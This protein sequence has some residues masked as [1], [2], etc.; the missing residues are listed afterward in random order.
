MMLTKNITYAFS[1]KR[2]FRSDSSNTG[3][4]SNYPGPGTENWTTEERVEYARN[5]LR[6]FI[7][8]YRE[9]QTDS[10][11]EE[12]TNSPREEQTDS[13]REGQEERRAENQL[14]SQIADNLEEEVSEG[15]ALGIS[16]G[17][18][19]HEE[20]RGKKRLRDS[21]D[22]SEP[23]SSKV[24]KGPE[25]GPGGTGGSSSHGTSAGGDG[26][27]LPTSSSDNVGYFQL[28]EDIFAYM[29]FLEDI[30]C[31]CNFAYIFMFLL[32]LIRVCFSARGFF[33]F[34]FLIRPY[35]YNIY[36]KLFSFPGK[37]IYSYF[38]SEK[39]R[40]M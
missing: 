13:P 29:S 30:A 33:I 28:C 20:P 24:F 15:E 3:N 32:T 6:A 11:R 36:Y 12:Q 27:S 14:D 34:S 1:H 19:T 40:A 21:E 7:A 18:N 10:P 22:D 23:L 38:L 2:N 4:G 16:E 5:Q 31:V 37:K 35:I 17:E 9:E 8:R 39:K 25:D 26:S